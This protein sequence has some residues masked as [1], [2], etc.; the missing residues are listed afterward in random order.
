MK[1]RG[2]QVC[3]EVVLAVLEAALETERTLLVHRRSTDGLSWMEL[4]QQ[5]WGDG[6]GWFTQNSVKL[7]PGQISQLRLALGPAKG[8]PPK[9]RTAS[10]SRGF[11]PRL[12]TA[13]SA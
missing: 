9:S 13:D 10:T 4:R 8:T 11:V 3:G 12:V 1:D 5:S 6:V 2:D 7:E